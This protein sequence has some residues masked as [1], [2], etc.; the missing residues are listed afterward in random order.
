MDKRV[1][2]DCYLFSLP[3]HFLPDRP[4]TDFLLR[5]LNG[6]TSERTCTHCGARSS[7]HAAS[8]P[9]TALM[10]SSPPPPS[11]CMDP[12]P[13]YRRGIRDA[14]FDAQGHQMGSAE[15]SILSPSI[16]D[17]SFVDIWITATRVY[18]CTYLRIRLR[19][20]RSRFFG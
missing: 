13:K 4:K 12:S 20:C 2:L 14:T 8:V 6:W 7:R 1:S 16:D 19:Q 9:L 17:R 18:M 3:L 15:A 11:F 10:F 5:A